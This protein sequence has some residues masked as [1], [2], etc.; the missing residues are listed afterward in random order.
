MSDAM[1]STA[2]GANHIEAIDGL[3]AVAVFAVLIFHADLGIATGGFLGVSLFFTLSGYLITTLLL[4]EHAARG[5]ISIKRFYG[6]RWRR[7]VPSAWVTLALI[8]AAA[9]LWSVPQLRALPGDTLA[10]LANVANWR[11]A[12]ADLSYQDL[13]IGQPSPLAHYWSLAIEEQF[14]LVMPLI[15]LLALRRSRRTLSVV[16][17]VLL[18]GSVVA[19]VLTSDRDLVYNGTHTRAAELLIGVLLAIHTPM[20]RHVVREIVGWVALAA[21]GVV[22]AL[23]SIGD[24]WIY[25]GGLAAFSL[26]SMALVV[27]V[28]GPPRTL[29]S[30]VL[31]ARPLVAIGHWSYALYLVHWP[32]YL[33]LNETRTG[34][35]PVPL[36]AVRTALALVLAALIT[37]VVER[38]IRT[39]RIFTAAHTTFAASLVAAVCLVVAI[40]VLP[41]PELSE[42]EQLLA[43]GESGQI[44]F[45]A[46]PE[47]TVDTLGDVSTTTVPPTPIL[48]VGSD[49]AAADELRASG[50]MVVD[51]TDAM[52]PITPALEV[53]LA[54]SQV[55]DTTGCA[56]TDSWFDAAA[57]RGI[58]DVVVT[59]GAIDEGVVRQ[60]S[61]VGFP[62]PVD[63]IGLSQR[64]VHV[65]DAIN[66]LWDAKP[67][68]VTVHLLQV[69]ERH[70]TLRST[71]VTFAASRGVFTDLHF[72]ISSIAASLS[73][74]DS[75]VGDLRVLV[76]GDSTST[77]LAAA[78]HRASSG[79]VKVLWTGSNG[80]PVVPID[81]VR[82]DQQAAWEKADCP[83][84]TDTVVDDLAAFRPDVVVLMVSGVELAHQRYPGDDRDHAAGDSEY[85]AVHD[86]YMRTL[87]ALL[88]ASQIPLLIAD[89]PQ[90]LPNSFL[91]EESASPARIA[92]WNL[93][94]ERWISSSS[95]IG[96]LP[97]AEAI[98][99]RQTA[100]P[101][102]VVLLDGIH[103][104]L[105]ILTEL[106]RTQLLRVIREAA[107]LAK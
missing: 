8:L 37:A 29:F 44:I 85:I 106:V 18:A 76:L 4:R 42:N 49:S 6:R 77:I 103:P 72:S 34:L 94:V 89:C 25:R 96:L 62:P 21:F 63:I 52:C 93:Q 88:R 82:P 26:I 46:E 27:A 24:E 5:T 65:S 10:A 35:R 98:N 17:S 39:R 58:A 70:T 56:D 104:D 9:P 36:F 54:T 20:L 45:S 43:A 14:Y 64:S 69:G 59:F 40:V 7:L 61:E 55:V 84:K 73:A 101:D 3:R 53:Q 16:V 50:L 92:A 79:Q 107:A 32:I 80:C 74:I 60:T 15:A 81:A 87:D 68:A 33:A 13:F 102:E 2:T 1:T 95:N 97:Y 38:P 31:S 57:E 66:A 19:T 71:L 67:S 51:L 75:A 41:R 90:L 30:A 28:I 22:V 105:N 47:D 83:S 12:F 23:T 48:V 91:A 11:A 86:E 78:I 100:N 99:G